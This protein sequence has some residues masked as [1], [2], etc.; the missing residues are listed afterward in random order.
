M[1]LINM[2]KL[3]KIKHKN[4]IDWIF[5][6]LEQDISNTEQSVLAKS[7]HLNS[8]NSEGYNNYLE[9]HDETILIENKSIS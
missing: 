7:L 9:N 2:K 8:K 6:K 4:P 5:Y 3:I 1:A